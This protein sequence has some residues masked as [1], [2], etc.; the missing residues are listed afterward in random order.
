MIY[1]ECRLKL[2]KILG[3]KI[4]LVKLYGRAIFIKSSNNKYICN[5]SMRLVGVLSTTYKNFYE[6]PNES[7]YRVADTLFKLAKTP[8]ED[9]K[10]KDK[11]CLKH[12]YLGGE[13][14]NNY[15]NFYKDKGLYDL[16][17]FSKNSFSQAMFTLDEIENIKTKLKTDLSDFE[18]PIKVEE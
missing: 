18:D 1:E 5:V 4:E 9:R 6:L 17:Y 10:N 13:Y 7:K 15:L 11:Y 14:N 3:E 12:K 16:S 2:E 8:I